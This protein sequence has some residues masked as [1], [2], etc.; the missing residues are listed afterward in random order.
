M[1]YNVCSCMNSR[2]NEKLARTIPTHPADAVKF[3]C[4][5][6]DEFLK[7]V[8]RS[9]SEKGPDYFIYEDSDDDKTMAEYFDFYHALA[10][11]KKQFNL[12][13]VYM[14]PMAYT[15]NPNDVTCLEFIRRTF[16]RTQDE[17]QS[18]QEPLAKREG[19]D[20]LFHN[21]QR[22]IA[23]LFRQNLQLSEAIERIRD[24]ARDKDDLRD[25]ANDFLEAYEV[26]KFSPTASA[27]L[28]RR[29]LQ[30]IL[31]DKAKVSKNNLADQIEETRSKNLFPSY[32]ADSLDAVRHIGNFAAHPSKSRETGLIVAVERGEA[33]WTLTVIETLLDFYFMQPRLL[34]QKKRDLK[35]RLADMEKNV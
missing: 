14:G 21:S 3:L 27:A 16:A 19:K 5:E 4:A 26:L 33:E 2:I 28:G 17:L 29:N 30:R 18:V 1:G 6:F 32:I 22:R 9:R 34:D 12:D 35:E 20:Q 11:L 31:R 15:I 25:Y 7:T 23:K 13:Y 8:P 10:V 24:Y